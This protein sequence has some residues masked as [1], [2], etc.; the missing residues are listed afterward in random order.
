MDDQAITP[1]HGT[2]PHRR[3]RVRVRVKRKRSLFERIKKKLE[4][5]HLRRRERNSRIAIGG[6]ILFAIFYLAVLRPVLDYLIP[7]SRPK[8]VQIPLPAKTQGL[9]LPKR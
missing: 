8:Q 2:D 5:P 4:M 6:V 3:V 7:P 1:P 9:G